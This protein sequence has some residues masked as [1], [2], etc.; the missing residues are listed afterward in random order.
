MKY[1]KRDLEAKFLKMS[2]F[3]KAILVTETFFI[4]LR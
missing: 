4:S 1:I 2:G 3:F